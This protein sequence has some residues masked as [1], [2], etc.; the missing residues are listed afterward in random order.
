VDL[1]FSKDG[2]WVVWEDGN[3]MDYVD[4]QIHVYDVE[5]NRDYKLTKGHSDNCFYDWVSN[6]QSNQLEDASSL[7]QDGKTLYLRHQYKDAVLKYQKAVDL[8][9]KND[10]AYGLM[11]YSYFRD[12]DLNNSVI[13][14]KKSIGINS[15][16]IMSHYNLALVYWAKQQKNST[17]EE[18][19]KVYLLDKT[20]KNKFHGDPQFKEIIN[21]PEYKEIEKKAGI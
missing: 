8:D 12:G 13:A 10:T 11:G 15:N 7:I 2:K 17:I 4:R 19:Q 14:L 16:N 5:A 1:N 21:T 6:P 18:I 3:G 9:P 20:Y